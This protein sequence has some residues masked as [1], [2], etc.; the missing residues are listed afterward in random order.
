MIRKIVIH[1]TLVNRFKREAIKALPHEHIVAV[2]G[3]TTRGIIYVHALDELEVFAKKS[4]VRKDT[5]NIEYY[6]PEVEIEAGSNLKYFGTL[7]THPNEDVP[8]PSE[9]DKKTFWEQYNNE[10]YVAENCE[11]EIL[12]D[13]IMGIMSL[14]KKGKSVKHNLA[15]YNIDINTIELEIRKTVNG[16]KHKNKN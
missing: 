6:Q 13:E 15:F 8:T 2:L 11:N 7:H 5:Y 14:N 12:R 1:N 3:K 4:Q 16:R 10:F 9:L